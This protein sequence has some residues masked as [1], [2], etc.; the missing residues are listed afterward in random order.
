MTYARIVSDTVARIGDLLSGV[1]QALTGDR[2]G[3]DKTMRVEV[4]VTIAALV[5]AVAAVF[6]VAAMLEPADAS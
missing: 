6:L 1:R 2:L 3:L 5:V 4:V